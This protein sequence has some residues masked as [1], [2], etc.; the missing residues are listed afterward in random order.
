LEENEKNLLKILET[1]FEK[2]YDFVEEKMDKLLENM[3]KMD[4][5]RSSMII[6]REKIQTDEEGMEEVLRNYSSELVERGPYNKNLMDF[7][8]KKSTWMRKCLI[9]FENR[10]DFFSVGMKELYKIH[11]PVLTN[12]GIQVMGKK[13]EVV[14]EKIIEKIVEIPQVVKEEMVKKLDVEISPNV[15]SSIIGGGSLSR[16]AFSS[17]ND[18]IV[19]QCG[20]GYTLF[21]NGF[22]YFS[23]KP[24]DCKSSILIFR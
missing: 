3:K 10:I 15:V 20:K 5:K 14:V 23:E 1:R 2:E 11:N 13:E 4:Q 19:T 8:N 18:F 22:E 12:K 24:A 17:P 21:K 9:Q 6:E 16:V 7:F